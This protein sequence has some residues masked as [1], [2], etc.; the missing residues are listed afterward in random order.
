[1]LRND[2]LRIVDI[3]NFGGSDHIW[4]KTAASTISKDTSREEVSRHSKMSDFVPLLHLPLSD[5]DGGS[6]FILK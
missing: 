2:I 6:F 3:C 4:S 1:M 5:N